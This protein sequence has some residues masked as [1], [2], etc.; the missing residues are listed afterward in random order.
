KR[1]ELLPRRIAVARQVAGEHRVTLVLK[2]ARSLV[3]GPAG[4]V[5]IVPT[6]NPG[7][8]TGGTGDVLTGLIAGLLARGVP[9][10]LAARAG[11]Y[12]HGLAGDIAAARVGPEAMLAGDLLDCLPEAIRQVKTGKNVRQ[13][14]G[15]AV[16]LF[17]DPDG[18][19]GQPTPLRSAVRGGDGRTA[20]RY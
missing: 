8:A 5:A 9:P 7:M 12:V 18:T 13:F 19:A 17:A 16:Q 3:A 14:G 2:T 4:E 15:S 1:A 11:A 20:E 6:G 10:G